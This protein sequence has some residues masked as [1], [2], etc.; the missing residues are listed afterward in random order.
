VLA[1]VAIAAALDH[2]DADHASL[3]AGNTKADDCPM[4]YHMGAI[5]D[6]A[7]KACEAIKEVSVCAKGGKCD[8][9]WS[10]TPNFMKVFQHDSPEALWKVCCFRAYKIGGYQSCN[11]P[12]ATC[13]AAVQEHV[14]SHASG[15]VDWSTK[16]E[17]EKTKKSS[18]ELLSAMTT[19]LQRLQDAR[20]DMYT[21]S[22]ACQSKLANPEPASKCGWGEEKTVD[23]AAGIAS[24]EHSLQRDDLY[25]ETIEWQYNQMGAADSFMK[26]CRGAKFR[27]EKQQAAWDENQDKE[28]KKDGVRPLHSRLMKA[29]WAKYAQE[30]ARQLSG[31]EA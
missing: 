6:V 9:R 16:M 10:E 20:A 8:K 5:L 24:Q 19:I 27:S 29:K 15:L 28:I 4:A 31:V 23:T 12:D 22:G 3:Q 2:N 17:D 7:E 18:E 25:C 13:K 30:Y 11:N 1:L 21:K 26:K 14:L